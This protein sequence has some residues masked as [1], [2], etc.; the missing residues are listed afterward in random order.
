MVPVF[1][2][3]RNLHHRR[4]P[5][6]PSLAH[7]FMAMNPFTRQMKRLF[8]FL[9]LPL[10]HCIAFTP[11]NDV[12]T[13]RAS[14]SLAGITEW[15]D[16]MFNFPGTGDDRRI[17]TEA[18]PPPKEICLLPF[19]FIDCLLQGETKQLRLYE[20]RFIQLFD[21]AMEEHSGVVAMGKHR[22]RNACNANLCAQSHTCRFDGQFWDHSNRTYL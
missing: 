16:T 19:P 21:K 14:T 6:R 20:D 22:D 4:L 7:H 1:F 8:L 2:F 18:G 17:G 11:K 10:L 15:R 3:Q 13:R 5:A 12:R 9:I